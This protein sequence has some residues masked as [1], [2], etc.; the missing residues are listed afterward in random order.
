MKNL[1]N[2]YNVNCSRYLRGEPNIRSVFVIVNGNLYY[3]LTVT[4]FPSLTTSFFLLFTTTLIYRYLR[5]CPSIFPFFIPR[6]ASSFIL[7]N[8]CLPFP[9]MSFRS[10]VPN[11]QS[12]HFCPLLDVSLARLLSIYNYIFRI[13]SFTLSR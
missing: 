13:F 4:T 1:S 12:T 2:K 9:H 6:S 3:D 11:H 8:A 7:R 10:L 5:G